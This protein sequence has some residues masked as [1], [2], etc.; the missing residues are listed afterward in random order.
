[1]GIKSVSQVIFGLIKF[2]VVCSIAQYP[3]LSILRM[4]RF[5]NL[6]ALV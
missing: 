3:I 5:A 2:K 6:E 1:M 4:H